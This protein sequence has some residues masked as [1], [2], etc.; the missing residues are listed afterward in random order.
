MIATNSNATDHIDENYRFRR[1]VSAD[2]DSGVDSDV[3]AAMDF[4]DRNRY[5]RE[6]RLRL[7][8][9]LGAFVLN[10]QLVYWRPVRAVRIVVSV[11]MR[12][13]VVILAG[14]MSEA[15]GRHWNRKRD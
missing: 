9:V 2:S 10:G 11:L 8:A 13:P 14:F 5:I 3:L 7:M 6:C 4:S 1:S 12:R 15:R